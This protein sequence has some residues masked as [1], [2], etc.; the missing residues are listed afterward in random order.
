MR[1]LTGIR[2]TVAANDNRV[3]K[4]G[5]A[6]IVRKM[7]RLEMSFIEYYLFKIINVKNY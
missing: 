7:V 1:Y 2:M 6:D 3:A 5:V 4:T